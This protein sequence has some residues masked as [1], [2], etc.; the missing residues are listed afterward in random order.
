[1]S[2]FMRSSYFLDIIFA[3]L[4]SLIIFFFHHCG[5]GGEGGFV[6]ACGIF[7]KIHMQKG[8]AFTPHE[9]TSLAGSQRYL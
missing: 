1:M 6:G 7:P 2:C 9:F 4:L 8:S 5:G 3:F